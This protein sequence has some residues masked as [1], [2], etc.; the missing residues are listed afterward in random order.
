[1]KKFFYFFIFNLVFFSSNLCTAEENNNFRDFL[2]SDEI[3]VEEKA[4]EAKTEAGRLLDSAPRKIEIKGLKVESIRRGRE[5]KKETL[6]PPT[7]EIINKYG[8]APFGLAWG[9]NTSYI[10][11]TGVELEEIKDELNPRTFLATHLPKPGADFEKV[12]T[13]FGRDNKLWRII[14]YGTVFTD[15][16]RGSLVLKEYNKYSR[17]LEKKYGNKK[18]RF[19]PKITKIEKVKEI[20]KGETEVIVETIKSEIGGENFIKEI[21]NE[22]TTLYT[23]FTDGK[24]VIALSIAVDENDKSFIIIDYKNIELIKEQEAA[25]YNSI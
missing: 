16:S 20:S 6:T 2:I 4:N 3:I 7:P 12:S 15:N 14:A 17:L 8:E 22:E 21:K 10:R 5:T 23:T 9:T 1:M 24:L 25:A 18:E 11:D 13:Y 19:A